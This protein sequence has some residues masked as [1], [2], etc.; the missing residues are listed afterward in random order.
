MFSSKPVAPV[1]LLLLIALLAVA[2]IPASAQTKTDV[3]KAQA[4]QDRAYQ[5]LIEAN[6]AV[7]EAISELEGIVAELQELN[8]TI[9]RLDRKITEFDEQV[10]SLRTSAQ[11]LVVE[12]YT[13][14]GTGL[15]TAAFTAASIQD[16]LTSQT[17]IG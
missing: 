7:G 17:L 5:D 12:A 4:A 14:S 11:E 3:E 1:I 9:T 15:V 13:N 6:Q 16:L 10:E 8:Y 2:P